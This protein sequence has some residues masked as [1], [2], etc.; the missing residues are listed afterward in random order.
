[1][2]DLDVF[3]KIKC[4]SCKKEFAYSFDILTIAGGFVM[5]PA[6][7]H[8]HK[9]EVSE[10]DK[11]CPVCDER[12][13]IQ[14]DCVGEPQT[15]ECSNCKK[16]F[17]REELKEMK[18]YVALPEE[19]RLSE[20]EKEIFKKAISNNI[21][22][23][24]TNVVERIKQPVNVDYDEGRRVLIVDEDSFFLINRAKHTETNEDL[25][26]FSKKGV[27]KIFLCKEED[28]FSGI[29]ANCMPNVFNENI[30]K[31]LYTHFKGHVYEVVGTA[32]FINPKAKCKLENVV[33]YF[34][35][36]TEGDVHYGDFFARPIDMFFSPVD[37]EKYPDSKQ[38]Y[39]FEL[40]PS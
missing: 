4:H 22:E 24:K 29:V 16:E 18:D 39:R 37:R 15:G 26:V 13:Q 19:N 1:M 30:K 5:C 36:Y 6:C 33:L 11:I 35:R 23:T 8:V 12:I 3:H 17:T 27:E 2:L 10:F 7:K 9:L 31:G 25:V 32:F 34:A 40:M 20:E 38:V 28:F 21:I 14:V